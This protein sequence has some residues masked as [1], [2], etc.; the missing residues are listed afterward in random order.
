MNV[1]LVRFP[2]NIKAIYCWLPSNKWYTYVYCRYNCVSCI[3]FPNSDWIT[4]RQIFAIWL[5]LIYLRLDLCRNGWSLHHYDAI[6]LCFVIEC[7][8]AVELDERNWRKIEG[9]R[10][11]KRIVNNF[12]FVL[13]DS[14]FIQWTSAFHLTDHWSDNAKCQRHQA[15]SPASYCVCSDFVICEHL[16]R[17]LL[18]ITYIR[19]NELANANYSTSHK[20]FITA[21]NQFHTEIDNI[22]PDLIAN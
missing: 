10:L 11:W 13:S 3:L 15:A 6:I 21:P 8:K 1:I 14:Q 17:E 19:A 7:G 2:L 20:S 5:M 18:G 22:W 12:R 9:K 4:E 16:E